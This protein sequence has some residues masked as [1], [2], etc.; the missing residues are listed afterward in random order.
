[1]KTGVVSM[2][3]ALGV[4]GIC[5][6][7][8]PER[9]MTF[10]KSIQ[11][12]ITRKIVSLQIAAKRNDRTLPVYF[13]SFSDTLIILIETETDPVEHILTMANILL[14][15]FNSALARG[16]F[17]RGVISLGEIHRG[18][19]IIIGSGIDEAAISYVLPEWIGISLTPS[20]EL[21][22]ERLLEEGKDVSQCLVKY[23]VPT[24]HGGETAGN[25]ALS[26]PRVFSEWGEDNRF[27]SGR[28]HL[29]HVLSSSGTAVSHPRKYWNTLAFFDFD[30]NHRGDE[31]RAQKRKPTAT[32]TF[33]LKP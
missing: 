19:D 5:S 12:D 23:K 11:A 2:I 17:F 20:A 33:K 13:F 27:S 10:W 24:K 8:E 26:W 3:D 14:D 9:F 18:E 15:P 6:R 28:A 32:R 1:M 21:G 30:N 4:K 7:I 16:I 22:L 25:W 31:H 29:L